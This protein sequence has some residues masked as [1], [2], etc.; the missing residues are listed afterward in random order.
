MS[1]TKLQPGREA[2]RKFGWWYSH[3]WLLLR[4]LTQL[5]ILLLFLLGPWA[6]VWI[7]RGNLSSSLL[8]ETVP[9]TDPL[10]FLQ[11][12]VAGFVAPAGTAILGAALVLA[13]YA[14]VGGRVFCSWVCPVNP[15]TDLAHWLR[16]RL[17]LRG[18]MQI[19]RNLRF[20]LLGLV[21]VLAFATGTL[22]WELVNPVSLL[23]RGLIFGFGSALWVALGLFLFDL[24]V[25]RRGWCGHLCPLGAFYGLVGALSPLRVRTDNRAACDD[26]QECFAVCPE[27]QVIRP[28]IKGA[29]DG[30]APVILSGACSNCGRCIEVCPQRVFSFGLRL[31][32]RELAAGAAVAH[33]S[34]DH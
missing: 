8:L 32:N 12:L 26:C 6:G 17:G 4:R 27:P 14:L 16:E 9:M 15:V 30:A 31:P 21:L 24:L 23:H 20:W 11:M 5:G 1:G 2:T 28:A 3:R 18:G 34:D 19:P 29:A 33:E 10:L 25:A 13:L 7:L 22:A